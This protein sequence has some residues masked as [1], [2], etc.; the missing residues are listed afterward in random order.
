MAQFAFERSHSSIHFWLKSIFFPLLTTWQHFPVF[1]LN[2]E[3]SSEQDEPTCWTWKVGFVVTLDH[4]G[5]GNTE[6]LPERTCLE[7]GK[8]TACITSVENSQLLKLARNFFIKTVW[9]K[10]LDYFA[11]WN[12]GVYVANIVNSYNSAASMRTA[13]VSCSSFRLA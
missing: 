10:F 1:T 8:V 9:T 6:I 5:S 3:H 7:I 4:S 11:W 13:E 2:V 12:V